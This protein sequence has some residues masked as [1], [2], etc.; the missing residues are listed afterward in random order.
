VESTLI[1]NELWKEICNGDV[2]ETKHID[3]TSLAKWEIKDEKVL[4]LS[5]LKMKKYMITS[6][7]PLMHGLDGKQSRK[8]NTNF[9]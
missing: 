9:Q 4:A 5:Y 2:K 8:R 7:M 1:C 6:K 3:T